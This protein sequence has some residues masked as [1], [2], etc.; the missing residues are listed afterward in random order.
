MNISP[1]LEQFIRNLQVAG[2][3]I[4]LGE[5]EEA[6]VIASCEGLLDFTLPET[7][8]DYPPTCPLSKLDKVQHAL[9]NGRF[10]VAEN[11][12]IWL[13]D[14]DL[15]HRLLPFITEH[16]LLRIDA[17]RLVGTMHEAYKRIAACDWGFGVFIS[18]PSKTADIEQSL[19][20]GAHGARELTVI[21][22][23]SSV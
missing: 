2:A 6:Q 16:L 23:L 17:S 14:E 9:F 12:A 10:G 22:N 21:I 18:G 20:Y 8:A 5:A 4:A 11:G 3:Q 19:V 7:R 15:P 13:E 1:L